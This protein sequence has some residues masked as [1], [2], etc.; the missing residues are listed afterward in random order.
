MNHESATERLSD[1][2]DDEL[3][4]REREELDAHLA[5]CDDCKDVVAELRDLR[6]TARSL[7]PVPPPERVWGAVSE[8]I[9][10]S[11]RRAGW[12]ET[13]SIAWKAAAVLLLG[14]GL[15]LAMRT[16]PP[17]PETE[18][19]LAERVSDD[20]LAAE[21]H[22]ESAISGLEELIASNDG[23]L[24]DNLR[25]TLTDNL[26]VIEGSIEESRSAIATEPESAVA[27]ES[28]MEA[29][30]RK[31]SLLQNMVLLINE[32][33]KGE[34]ANALELIDEMQRTED[35]SNPI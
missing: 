23:A 28:L 25:K 22:Y 34:G 17:A 21:A 35:E 13:R 16:A 18:R 1:Y 6:R 29:F 2:I 27:R 15:W 20:L 14:V 11:A 9:A 8:E 10:S 24:P 32:V 12:R 33:R 3:D 19:E 5:D 7:G 31:L 26:D 4:A 30:Q